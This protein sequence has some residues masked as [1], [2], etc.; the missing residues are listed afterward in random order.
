MRTITKRKEPASLTSWRSQPGAT[1]NDYP[2][3]QH[4][5][6]AL[7]EEQLYLCAFCG[8]RIEDTDANLLVKTGTPSD[9]NR[10][11][12]CAH[13]SP[14]SVSPAL[15]LTW[16]NLLGSCFGGEKT[17]D[18]TCDVAQHDDILHIHPV[19]GN[20]RPE[21]VFTYGSDG[22]MAGKTEE[23]QL[24]V[25]VLRLSTSSRLRRARTGVWEGVYA[26]LASR[27]GSWSVPEL[28]KWRDKVSVPSNGKL[29]PFAQVILFILN[30]QIRHHGGVP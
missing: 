7:C 12:R 17:N 19:L 26:V 13:W 15:Q 28:M 20:L 6:T 16:S 21:D 2:G 30:R 14:Q 25:N 18:E 5:R 22:S 23:A 9:G 1:W 11:V 29:T 27:R 3:K 8:A 10:G 24:D 4:A